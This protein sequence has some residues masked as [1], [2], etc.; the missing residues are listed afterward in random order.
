MR[1]ARKLSTISTDAFTLSVAFANRPFKSFSITDMHTLFMLTL[2]AASLG[3]AIAL[4]AMYYYARLLRVERRPN[5]LSSRKDA[6]PLVE[7]VDRSL[8]R[9]QVERSTVLSREELSDETTRELERKR[10]E[11]DRLNA[12][13]ERASRAMSLALG[14]M[15]FQ[16][17]L[18]KA[19]HF[20]DAKPFELCS[21][22]E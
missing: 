4:G 8:I 10:K 3:G 18:G 17:E 20:E 9:A 22:D 16:C 7:P 15:S 19:R 13:A 14:S 12:Q 21:F 2:G 11:L 6:T 1:V 5:V